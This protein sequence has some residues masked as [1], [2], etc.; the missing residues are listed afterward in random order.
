MESFFF[1]VYQNRSEIWLKVWIDKKQHC[2]KIISMPVLWCLRRS[3]A[4]ENYVTK[5]KEKFWNSENLQLYWIDFAKRLWVSSTIY[6]F[7]RKTPLRSSRQNADRILFFFFARLI[8]GGLEVGKKGKETTKGAHARI[9][10]D[11]LKSPQRLRFF[12]PVHLATDE[13]LVGAHRCRC[14]T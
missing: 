2:E 7:G 5:S 3:F 13:R 9:E 12:S 6:I 11:T 8:S 14:V 1:S 4:W 10:F